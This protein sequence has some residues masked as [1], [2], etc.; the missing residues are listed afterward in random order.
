MTADDHVHIASMKSLLG[1]FAALIFLTVITVAVAYVD[2]GDL[3]LFTALFIASV[4]ATLVCLYFMH[5]R[6]DSGFN[7]LA[8]FGSIVF[9]MLFVGITLMDSGQ[10]QATINWDE[11]V[12]DH[13]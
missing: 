1:V 12:L 5:L 13:K 9:V 11:Q 3:N 7:R 8:F 4:K 6:H 2:L 10:Y